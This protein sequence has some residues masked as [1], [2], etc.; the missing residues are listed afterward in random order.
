MVSL[1]VEYL[2][3]I[4]NVKQMIFDKEGIPIDQQR[5][6]FAGKQLDDEKTL[7]DCKI[8]RESTVYILPIQ[9]PVTEISSEVNVDNERT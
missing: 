8:Q 7:F 4:Q 3:T 1:D 6:M 2:D 5:L 9:T